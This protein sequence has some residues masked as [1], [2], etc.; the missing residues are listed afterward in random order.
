[1][2]FHNGSKVHMNASQSFRLLNT[3]KY[4]RE[5]KITSTRTITK[6]FLFDKF[7]KLLTFKSKRVKITKYCSIARNYF[8]YYFSSIL[9]LVLELSC[10]NLYIIQTVS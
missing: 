4:T 10:R 7:L 8:N 2:F 9:E 1:M 6:R 3:K 5:A